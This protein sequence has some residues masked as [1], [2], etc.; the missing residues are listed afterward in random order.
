MQQLFF[1]ICLTG[2]QHTSSL[3]ETEEFNQVEHYFE[4]SFT[5]F[6]SQHG[7]TGLLPRCSCT[8]QEW[9]IRKSVAICFIRMVLGQEELF[10]Y[11]MHSSPASCL[12]TLAKASAF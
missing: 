8:S 7:C 9:L 12:K 10:K 4:L 2:C 5:R 11:L 6:F 1:F 3:E